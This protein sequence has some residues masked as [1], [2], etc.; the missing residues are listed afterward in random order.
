[1]SFSAFE[2]SQTIA[3]Q[4]GGCQ[5]SSGSD[6]TLLHTAAYEGNISALEEILSR[7]PSREA[8]NQRNHLG[9]TPLRLAATG[10]H[11][12]CVEKL[13]DSGARVDVPDVKGQTP[14]QMA[15]KN[16]HY[17]CAR[18]LLDR[19]ANPNGD[20]NNRQSPLSQAALLGR[21]D[22][23][24]LLLDYG[25]EPMMQ[26]EG[27]SGL[28]FTVDALQLSIAYQHYDC[29]QLLL[30]EGAQSTFSPF[31]T[32]VV[33]RG[34]W[35]FAH[36]LHQFGTR[37]WVRDH[38]GLYPWEAEPRRAREEGDERDSQELLAFLHRLKG[39][40]RSLKSCCR[41]SVWRQIRSVRKTASCVKQ[42]TGVPQGIL[43]YLSFEHL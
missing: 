5:D 7:R 22:L 3:A 11:T 43:Q 28:T 36:L 20:G 2:V 38:K 40:P 21:C 41:L 25:A 4:F 23:V 6:D 29:S 8:I 15:V 13:L 30:M 27:A 31:H 19:G 34:H 18:L 32:L 39:E 26:R 9:C 35:R 24:Q 37:L 42:L 12:R 17:D 14:L 1:M 16:V 10:G 33:Q